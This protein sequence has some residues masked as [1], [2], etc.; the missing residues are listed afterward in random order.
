MAIPG[1]Q[2]IML[3][4]LQ[5]VKNGE[6]YSLRSVVDSL[7][8]YFKLTPEEEK[9]LLL[10]GTQPLF[11]NRVGW[12]R[13]YLYKA[14]LLK[15]ERRGYFS[16]TNEGLELLKLNPPQIDAQLLGN[17]PEFTRFISTT[18]L[19][20]TKQKDDMQCDNQ[21]QTPEETL[22]NAYQ[23]LNKELADE[24][25]NQ[26]K[27]GLPSLFEQIVI[28]LL[29]KMGYGGNRKDAGEAIGKPRDEGIDGIIKEDKLGLDTIYIQ[30]KRW[31]NT[32][33]GRSEIQKFAGALQGQKA[34]KGIFIT[35]SSFSKE[36]QEYVS[37]IDTKIVLIDGERL[38]EL[39]IEN[40][41]GVNVLAN[42]EVKKIDYDYFTS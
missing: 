14:G 22:E 15:S 4:L 18:K 37:R 10:S 7:A 13:T 8:T 32:K 35:T 25:L 24:V 39:M 28:D 17:Y 34:R 40:N 33:I 27:T 29:V 11:Y 31:D 2:N 42:Y 19:K 9:Q 16:I 20:T 38:A 30:A 6:E 12:A 23:N 5:H 21:S 26:I 1:F 3:P 36:A 41:V